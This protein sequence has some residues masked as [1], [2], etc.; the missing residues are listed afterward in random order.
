MKLAGLCAGLGLMPHGLASSMAVPVSLAT[1]DKF[2][3]F[4]WDGPAVSLLRQ[5][6]PSIDYWSQKECG[7]I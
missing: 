4:G 5:H 1:H 6:N 7:F 3:G 2:P